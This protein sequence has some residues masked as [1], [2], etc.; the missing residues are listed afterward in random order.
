[1]QV[2]SASGVNNDSS[3][4]AVVSVCSFTID[5]V[6]NTIKL[7]RGAELDALDG[8]EEGDE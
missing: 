7:Q 5:T 6:R 4:P 8:D 3:H 2:V 1:M